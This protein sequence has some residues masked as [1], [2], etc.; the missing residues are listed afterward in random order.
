MWE[1][2]EEVF[3]NE[4]WIVSLLENT[5][6]ASCLENTDHH[7]CHQCRQHM[8]THGSSRVQKPKP[9]LAHSWQSSKWCAQKV[10][11]LKKM[12]ESHSNANPGSIKD[13]SLLNRG[14]YTS[15]SE[16]LKIV[17]NKRTKKKHPQFRHPG[18]V[19]AKGNRFPPGR[20]RCNWPRPTVAWQFLSVEFLR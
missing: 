7:F 20:S 5:W 14:K 17:T 3:E 6:D 10:G 1:M 4:I 13:P 19:I 9:E 15:I 12:D 18:L 16:M 11:I 8:L 2:L